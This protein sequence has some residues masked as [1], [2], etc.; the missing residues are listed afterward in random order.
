M[1]RRRPRGPLWAVTFGSLTLLSAA[2]G[3]SRAAAPV[4]RITESTYGEIVAAA[5]P[6]AICRA[7]LHLPGDRIPRGHP[8]GE[9]E[10]TNGL[11]TWRYQ[12][13][14]NLHGTA[15]HTVTCTRRSASAS[16]TAWF[17]LT[18]GDRD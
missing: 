18:S 9:P 13:A 3:E 7:E 12:T 8:L 4:V 10:S 5:P 6:G 2:C 1:V 17:T 14:S 15:S 16:A 11:L